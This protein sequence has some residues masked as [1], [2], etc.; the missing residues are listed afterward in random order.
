[1]YNYKIFKVA[2]DKTSLKI[3]FFSVKTFELT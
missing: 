1:M 2:Y 3:Q